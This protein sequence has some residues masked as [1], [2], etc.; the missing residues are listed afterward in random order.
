MNWFFE[1]ILL[2]ENVDLPP[3]PILYWLSSTN[4][5]GRD[6][7]EFPRAMRLA[8]RTCRSPRRRWS[9]PKGKISQSNLCSIDWLIGWTIHQFF[10]WLIDWLIDWLLDWSIDWLVDWLVNWLVGWLIDRLI[11]WLIDWWMD[12]LFVILVHGE[13]NGITRE[14]YLNIR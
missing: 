1:L 4:H 2:A 3:R 7:F 13:R 5:A 12:G 9:V 14:F 8:W 10:L 11:D 6:E